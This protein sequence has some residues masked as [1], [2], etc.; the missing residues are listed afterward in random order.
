MEVLMQK[1]QEIALNN[2][3]GT[4]NK[5]LIPYEISSSNSEVTGRLYTNFDYALF[6]EYGTG[7]KAEMPHIGTSET[8]IKSNFSYW[9]LPVSMVERKLNNPVIS[10]KGEQFYIMFST[11][12]YPFMRPTLFELENKAKG[13]FIEAL[14]KE[15]RK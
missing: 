6:L 1:A 9:F 3:R 13:M 4:R 5:D 2:K 12:P 14:R 11:Q 10:I 7:K 8:F 15:I